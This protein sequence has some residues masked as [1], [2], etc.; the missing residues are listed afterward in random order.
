MKIS[1]IKSAQDKKSFEIFKN[2]GFDVFEVNNPEEADGRIEELINNNYSTIIISNE[3][4]GFSEN[5]FKKYSSS[6]KVKIII[7]PSKRE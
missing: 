1:W 4:A 7:T 2:L 3:L 6:Q 5:I